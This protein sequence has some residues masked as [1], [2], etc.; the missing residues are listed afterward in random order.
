MTFSSALLSSLLKLPIITER[1]T[2][3]LLY[4]RREDLRKS[5][6]E[7]IFVRDGALPSTFAW[8]VPSPTNLT[9]KKQPQVWRVQINHSNNRL[10]IL[11]ALPVKSWINP[12]KSDLLEEQSFDQ[13]GP[14]KLTEELS[15]TKKELEFLRKEKEERLAEKSVNCKHCLR[16]CSVL[17]ICRRTPT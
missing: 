4:F 11:L 14:E 7:R 9:L 6:N 15:R 1:T 13:S 10:L 12:K 5:S 2:V 16:A 3:C 17:A 8:S